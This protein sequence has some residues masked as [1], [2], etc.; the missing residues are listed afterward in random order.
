MW[1]DPK[2]KETIRSLWREIP[3]ALNI[4]SGKLTGWN[5]GAWYN[6]CTPSFNDANRTFT[7]TPL[8]PATTFSYFVKGLKFTKTGAQSFQITDITAIHYIVFNGAAFQETDLAGWMDAVKNKTMCLVAAIYWNATQQKAILKAAEPHTWD[9]KGHDHY[10]KHHTIGTHY[11]GGLGLSIAAN[12]WQLDVT[13]GEILDE[14]IDIFIK[15]NPAVIFGQNLT[16]L[17]CKKIYR[18][19][20]AEWYQDEEI[21]ANAVSLSAGNKVQHNIKTGEVWTLAETAVGKYSAM[22]AIATDDF[23]GP[24]VLVAGQGETG[25]LIAARAGNDY[26]NMNFSGLPSA[27]FRLLGRVIVKCIAAAPYYEVIEILQLQTDDIIPGGDVT[28]DSYVTAANFDEPSRTLTLTRNNGLGDLGVVIA[29]PDPYGLP[30][31][32]PTVLGGVKIG[33]GISIVDGVISV[34]TTFLE[35]TDVID[36]DYIGKAKYIPMVED[37]EDA[38]KLQETVQL[39]TI[40]AKFTLLS[41][42]PATLVGQGGKGLR[43]KADETGIEFYTL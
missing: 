19:G 5:P 13:E 20:L 16:V 26:A 3:V 21:P 18:L 41:D 7:L 1:P 31:A 29:N 38:M 6:E 4:L 27:E 14:D 15:D 33:T 12:N 23:D 10:W 28:N 37:T 36:E 22:W 35:L 42:C 30:T 2:M 40:L 43:V 25:T 32:T 8:S 24:V 34:S 9:S 17:E 11:G 39:Q